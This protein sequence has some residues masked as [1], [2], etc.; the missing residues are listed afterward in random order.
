MISQSEEKCGNTGINPWG[1]S[2][3]IKAST[4]KP[5]VRTTKENAEDYDEGGSSS[6]D[7]ED[8]NDEVIARTG[9]HNSKKN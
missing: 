6:D 9:H 2:I 7:E 3:I 8:D 4:P 1:L 5:K